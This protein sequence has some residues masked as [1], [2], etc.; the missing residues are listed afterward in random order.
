MKSRD[1][2]LPP[3]RLPPLVGGHRPRWGE[4]LDVGTVCVLLRGGGKEPEGNSGLGEIQTRKL[5]GRWA[6]DIPEDKARALE[7]FQLRVIGLCRWKL[8][9]LVDTFPIDTAAYARNYQSL[10]LLGAGK[11]TKNTTDDG[12]TVDHIGVPLFPVSTESPPTW[13]PT[14]NVALKE[15][16]CSLRILVT[17]HVGYV[18]TQRRL[19]GGPG[20]VLAYH[21]DLVYSH[22]DDHQWAV[23]TAS[24]LNKP[25]DGST[26][27]TAG[28]TL[29][30]SASQRVWASRL[31]TISLGILFSKRTASAR[32]T[33]RKGPSC[34]SKAHSPVARRPRTWEVT[35]HD[36]RC[37]QEGLG[38]TIAQLGNAS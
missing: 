36:T 7:R 37:T 27:D 5:Q 31:S 23:T 9:R 13:L 18:N 30:R 19:V 29:T 22:D 25:R 26:A 2:F 16:A 12:R 24:A 10:R 32:S 33:G 3:L 8:N 17:Y 20:S 38:H 11:A 35:M 6:A 4:R 1:R 34:T 28:P 21:L 15:S 14:A